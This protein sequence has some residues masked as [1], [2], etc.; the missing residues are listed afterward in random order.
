[1][2]YLDQPF[3]SVCYGNQTT[4]N[5]K[6][7][8]DMSEETNAVVDQNDPLNS[9][10][11]DKSTI[12]YSLLA[13]DKTLRFEIRKPRVETTKDGKGKN[14]V[15]PC[16]TTQEW[17]YTDG[18][19][20]N[21]GSVVFARIYVT[22]TEKVTAQDI[23]NRVVPWGVAAGVRGLTVGQI[24]NDP[25]PFDGKLVNCA[26]NIEPEKTDSKT[27]KTFP[28]SNSLKPIPPA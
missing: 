20:A 12:K 27:G 14:L 25:S 26:I 10:V 2:A 18:R 8:N 16:Y 19:V 6:Q 5:K 23:V 11:G 4:K 17:Q 15:F 3:R 22:P 24:I 9:D 21:K 13:G 7:K 28:E 1:M